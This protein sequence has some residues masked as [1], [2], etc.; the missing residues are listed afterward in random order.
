MSFFKDASPTGGI[1]DLIAYL[2]EKREYNWLFWIAACLPPTIMVYMFQK[3]MVTKSV[4]PPPEVIYFESWPAD[5]SR[6]ET[7]KD[8]T[9]R[10]AKKDAFLEEKRKGYE[11]LGRAMGMDVEA[12]KREADQI[13]ADARAA[14]AKAEAEAVQA[15]A[16][17]GGAPSSAPAPSPAA[18]P[19]PTGAA[20]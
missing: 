17:A 7:I 14:A 2:R 20:Q 5:R 18:S 8:I 12:I 6:E 4:P 10:Q 13:K 19:A 3:D 1:A 16:K 15:S 9:A 11:A